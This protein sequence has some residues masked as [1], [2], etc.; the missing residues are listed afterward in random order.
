[1]IAREK[2]IAINQARATGKPEAMVEKIAE[3]KLNKVL[4][5]ITLLDQLFVKDPSTKIS[6]LIKKVAGQV[7]DSLEV[8]GFVRLKVGEA[9]A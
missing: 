5:E 7:S 9:A 8:E 6:D 1:L 3:G 4:Q 2:D